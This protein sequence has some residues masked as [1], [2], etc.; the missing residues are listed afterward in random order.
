MVILKET[1]KQEMLGGNFENLL[2]LLSKTHGIMSIE[3]KGGKDVDIISE[4]NFK[5][6]AFNLA[7]GKK[8]IIFDNGEDKLLLQYENVK[9]II[10]KSS[11][12]IILL[13][14]GAAL[15]VWVDD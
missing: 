4:I 3:L 15:Y 12:I 2:Q 10:C 7:P 1:Q 8:Q 5:K 11:H 13:K 6:W 9:N 14:S